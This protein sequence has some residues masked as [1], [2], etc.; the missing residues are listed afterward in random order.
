MDNLWKMELG[1]SFIN[2]L[3]INTLVLLQMQTLVSFHHDL[4]R[5]VI[6]PLNIPQSY[7]SI[8]SGIGYPILG[9]YMLSS[10]ILWI[11]AHITKA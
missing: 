2:F 9:S 1:N 5:W 11:S 10:S 3:A 6:Y 4:S 8:F 7:H